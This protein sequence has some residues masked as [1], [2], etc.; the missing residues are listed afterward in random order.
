L[1]RQGQ[2]AFG[3]VGADRA[4][5]EITSPRPG[6]LVNALCERGRGPVRIFLEPTGFVDESRQLLPNPS[7]GAAYWTDGVG[8]QPRATSTEP[9]P[10]L[11]Q[12][13]G[14][15]MTRVGLP[16]A[17]EPPKYQPPLGD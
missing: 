6:W 4:S 2:P 17:S 1:K 13:Q 7:A 5:L 14:Q 12:L 11:A 16:L 8:V 10:K 9:A 15:T 3:S